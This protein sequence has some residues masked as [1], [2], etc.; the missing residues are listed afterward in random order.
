MSE[1]V[2]TKRCPYCAEEI[3]VEAIKCRYCGSRLDAPASTR[4]WQ[5]SRR[6]RVAGVCAG[7][8]DEFDISVTL[9]RLAFILATVVGGSGIIVYLALWVLMPLAPETEA[10][11]ALEVT[12]PPDG[13]LRGPD[14]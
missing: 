9:V 7:L 5:R 14:L 12:P 11:E 2:A 4:T 1:T 13:H 6:R 3:R 8:A 10:Q